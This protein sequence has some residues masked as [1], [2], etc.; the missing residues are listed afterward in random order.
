MKQESS[1]ALIDGLDP[2]EARALIDPALQLMMDA[3]HQYD[4][5][6]AQALAAGENTGECWYKAEM[7]RLKGE[8][9][10]QSRVRSPKFPTPST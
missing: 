5:Y 8:L 9:S 1:M 7:Y 3:V 10:L 4:G 2:E 6:V